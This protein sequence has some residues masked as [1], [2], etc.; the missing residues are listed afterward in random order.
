MVSDKD[1]YRIVRYLTILTFEHYQTQMILADKFN[2]PIP[3][4]MSISTIMENIC[5]DFG[6][7][8][9]AVLEH[10][11]LADWDK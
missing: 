6:L 8:Y 7:P 11:K 3:P 5:K 4:P 2:T 10:S 1:F 9:Q